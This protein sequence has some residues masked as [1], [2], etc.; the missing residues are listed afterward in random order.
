MDQFGQPHW[1]IIAYRL[2]A[3]WCETCAK[4]LC[5]RGLEPVSEELPVFERRAVRECGIAGRLALAAVLE[6]A[7]QRW[8]VSRQVRHEFARCTG[9]G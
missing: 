9:I 2:R 5:G 4:M 6:P 3:Q 1:G 7:Q 8:R